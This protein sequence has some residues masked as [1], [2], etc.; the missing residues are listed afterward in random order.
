MDQFPTEIDLS[1]K[2]RGE[3]ERWR[4]LISLRTLLISG[5][6]SDGC[7]IFSN[8][9]FIFSTWL[10]IIGPSSFP[11]SVLFSISTQ[12]RDQR[13]WNKET[14]YNK[15][16]HEFCVWSRTEVRL[17]RNAELVSTLNINS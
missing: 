6:C 10:C 14:L 12:T 15:R 9:F 5:C 17:V 11:L 1:P 8:S 2:P 3:R 16:R 4:L 13:H 7:L